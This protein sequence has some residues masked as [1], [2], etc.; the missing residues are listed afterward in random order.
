MR[1]GYS[2][3]LRNLTLAVSLLALAACGGSPVPPGITPPPSNPPPPPGGSGYSGTLVAEG[4]GNAH[5]LDLDTYDPGVRDPWVSRDT[6]SVYEAAAVALSQNEILIAG[7]SFG[8]LMTVEV[9]DLTT[10]GLKESFEWS[11]DESVGRVNALAASRD[12]KHLAALLKGGPR[13]YLEVLS[14]DDKTVVYSGLDIVSDDTLAWTPNDELVLAL[15]LS[16]EGNPERWGAI[17]VIPLE[18]FQAATDERIV[19]D[20]YATFTR[21]EWDAGVLDI[22]LSS[23]GSQLAYTRGSDLWVMDFAPGA[24]PHQLTT[25]PIYHGGA[26]FSP[27]GTAIAFAA[28]GAYGLDETYIIPN[29]RNEPLFIDVGQ[30]AGDEYLIGVDTLVDSVLAWAP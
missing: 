10:F 17:G 5:T 14:R 18:R 29:H 3:Y 6:V 20:L 11:D 28:G 19:I 24:T 16:A 1:L 15:D 22:A 26:Q 13:Q 8:S 9:K 30:N 27:D 2:R 7:D 4:T 23:D 25:G 12:G 21:G